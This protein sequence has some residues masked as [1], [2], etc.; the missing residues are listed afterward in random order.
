MKY[1]DVHAHLNLEE[2]SDDVE[3]IAEKTKKDDVF[4]INV[5]TGEKSSVYAFELAQ[6][7]EHMKAIIGLH[8]IYASPSYV[9]DNPE[10]FNAGFYKKLLEKDI[11][12][13]IVAIGECGL[14][15][16]HGNEESKLL[17]KEAFCAQIELAIEK[18]LPLMLH[19]RPSE[20]SFDAYEDTLEIIREYKK[21]APGLIG[22]VHFFAGT[23]EIAREFLNL[24]FYIS[25]TGV[26]TFADSYWD[27]VDF[28]PLDRILSE[29][30]SPYVAPKPFRGKRNEPS[31]VREVVKKIAEIKGLEEK[32][33]E[34]QIKKNVES[35]FGF[36]Y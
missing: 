26:I 7:Y 35:L 36:L 10:V 34:N 13:N 12:K 33:V 3:V 31:H 11:H 25:F 4:V 20:N 17:Q 30:D 8:P 14:D 22:D 32:T 28:V 9:P 23:K 18:K 19:I 2:F 5:G 1:I 24:G 27:L 15:Y 16:F 6:R 29:T 21:N